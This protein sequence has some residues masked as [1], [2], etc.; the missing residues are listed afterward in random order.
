MFQN[1]WEI[2]AVQTVENLH[3]LSPMLAVLVCQCTVSLVSDD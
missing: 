2:S 1:A 3:L